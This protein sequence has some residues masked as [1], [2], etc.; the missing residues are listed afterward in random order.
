MITIITSKRL[1]QLE[2]I[3]QREYQLSARLMEAHR[4]LSEFDWL[5]DS[6]WSHV[7]E[8]AFAID[9]LRER[10]RDQLKV[11]NNEVVI[12]DQLAKTQAAVKTQTQEAVK[13][14][15]EPKRK[16]KKKSRRNKK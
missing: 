14:A 12:E 1:K 7:F 11:H 13:E 15:V 9:F 16:R 4:W 10:M 5:L 3:E 8:G 2:E 6:F